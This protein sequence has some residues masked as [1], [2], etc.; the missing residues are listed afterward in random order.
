MLGLPPLAGLTDWFRGNAKLTDIIYRIDPPGFSFLPAGA[1]V[2]NPIELMQAKNMSELSEYIST[3]F[4]WV[5]IDSTPVVSVADATVWAAQS[6]AVV[7]IAR[8]GKTE[9]RPLQKALEIV[10]R[11]NLIGVVLNGSKTTIYNRYYQ[12]YCQPRRTR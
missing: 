11:H 2:E 12:L 8:E 6:D 1:P 5:I 7:L 9:K 4:D 10:S 3:A